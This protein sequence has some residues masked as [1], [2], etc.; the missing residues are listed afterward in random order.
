MG[1]LLKLIGIE[2]SKRTM[3]MAREITPKL[4]VVASN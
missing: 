1:L 4:F 3:L 2:V